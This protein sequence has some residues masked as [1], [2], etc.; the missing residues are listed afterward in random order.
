ML[1][2]FLVYLL[3]A[4]QVSAPD[5]FDGAEVSLEEDIFFD[6]YSDFTPDIV[7]RPG[8]EPAPLVSSAARDSVVSG[9]ANFSDL[10]RQRSQLWTMVDVLG[11]EFYGDSSF[12]FDRTY[13]IG[14][15]VFYAFRHWDYCGVLVEERASQTDAVSGDAR[16]HSDLVAALQSVQP[17]VVHVEK[18]IEVP[19]FVEVPK[20][21]Y[22]PSSFDLASQQGVLSS[23]VCSFFDEGTPVPEAAFAFN[24]VG[25]DSEDASHRSEG[26]ES[27]DVGLV[28]YVGHAR[29]YYL[30]VGNDGVL[31][32]PWQWHSHFLST[33]RDLEKRRYHMHADA[34]LAAWQDEAF[35]FVDNYAS[36]VRGMDEALWVA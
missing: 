8:S 35:N 33:F 1:R 14:A 26:E 24:A 9:S 20:I 29:D 3:V 18:L 23:G 32:D 15:L 5:Y 21:V 25:D 13:G 30:E 10:A 27:E 2:W 19:K 34:D 22:L 31:Y 4:S 11:R 12:Y 36:V 17:T 28:L 16:S 6:C 7:L